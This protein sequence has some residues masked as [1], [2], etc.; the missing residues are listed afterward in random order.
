MLFVTLFIQTPAF[1]ANDQ[2]TYST[3]AWSRDEGRA[4]DHA[5]IVKPRGELSEQERH[6]DWPCTI[7]AEDQR[8]LNLI[9][10]AEVTVCKV[11]ADDMETALNTALRAGF[12]INEIIGYRVGRTKGV[13]DEN[14]KRTRYSH[15]SF[16][17][18]VDINSSVNGLY[19]NCT[20][21]SLRCRLL[22]GGDW[23]PGAPG[24]ITPETPLHGAITA[25]GWRWGGELVGRQKDFMHFSP[26]GD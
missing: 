8:T 6:P 21:F 16:G 12:P 26:S 11:I 17:L 14:G 2:C 24:A 3:W 20:E 23:R 7:C 19:D 22:R 10:G 18:A 1:A 13:L 4:V 9:N 5:D 15:H 25:M